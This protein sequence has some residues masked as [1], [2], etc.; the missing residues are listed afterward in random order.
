L[1]T[2][3]ACAA[4]AGSRYVV[5]GCCETLDDSRWGNRRQIVVCEALWRRFA[6]VALIV[7]VLDDLAPHRAAQ[8][9]NNGRALLPPSQWKDLRFAASTRH[10]RARSREHDLER[11]KIL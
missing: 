3:R 9:T 7:R 10:F 11:V 5:H 1:R 6:E 2:G 8:F 4:H